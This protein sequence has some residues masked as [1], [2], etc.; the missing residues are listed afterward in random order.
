MGEGEK[1]KGKEGERK[2][3]CDNLEYRMSARYLLLALVGFVV[4]SSALATE[5]SALDC[6]AFDRS[7]IQLVTFD[8][9][10]ALMDSS[11]SLA[12]NIA[13]LIP[14]GS[15]SA[16]VIEQIKNEWINKYASFA[17]KAFTPSETLGTH[18]CRSSKG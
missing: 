7:K 10:A 2:G 15:L 16:D 4:C 5:S 13:S 3:S 9:F 14:L 11:T 1:E 12:D 8:V 6:S 18:K 17:G